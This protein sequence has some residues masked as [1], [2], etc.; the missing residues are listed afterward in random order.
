MGKNDQYRQ[1]R[2]SVVVNFNNE[3]SAEGLARKLC[4]KHLHQP[5]LNAGDTF[6]LPIWGREWKQHRVLL[7]WT[8]W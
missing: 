2:T 6:F 4:E 5:S 7:L 3:I 8:T 1:H